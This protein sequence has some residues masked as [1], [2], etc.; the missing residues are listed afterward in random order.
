MVGTDH[1]RCFLV[2]AEGGSRLKGV[3]FRAADTAL[4][5]TLLETAGGPLHV[6]GHLKADRW[7]GRDAVELVIEDAARP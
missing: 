7:Q 4:G 1:V 5:R 2:G 3:A 6:A